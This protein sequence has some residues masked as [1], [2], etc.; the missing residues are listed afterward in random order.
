[1]AEQE[2]KKNRKRQAEGI[3]VACSERV[4]FGR[5]RIEIDD[6]F[7]QVYQEWIDGFITGVL[8]VFVYGRQEAGLCAL[9]ISRSKQDPKHG[10]GGT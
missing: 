10:E 9:R 6:R 1:M 5:P 4:T 8:S 7:L 3:E 2:R